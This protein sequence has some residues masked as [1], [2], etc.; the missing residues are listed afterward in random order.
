MAGG[1]NARCP[2]CNV[3]MPRKGSNRSLIAEQAIEDFKVGKAAEEADEQARVEAAGALEAATARAHVAQA[4]ADAA[5]A[6]L[7]SILER[8]PSPPNVVTD[9]IMDVDGGQDEGEPEPETAAGGLDVEF[10]EEGVNEEE[11]AVEEEE[12]ED[13]A[14]EAEEEEEEEEEVGEPVVAGATVNDVVESEDEEDDH[15]PVN[16]IDKVDELG[17]TALYIATEK[18]DVAAV[19]ALVAAGAEVDKENT[20]TVTPL[21]AAS[22]NGHVAVV[23]ALLR[24]G[25]AVNKATDDGWTP[26]H[27]AAVQGHKTVL[28]AGAYTRPLL[29]ST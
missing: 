10:E 3:H 22:E 7:A 2:T 12:V 4:R 24:A 16:E 11:A 28:A 23:R 19:R 14:E 1:V 18:G 26:L 27:G 6:L 17:R 9:T 8:P 5:E 29:S 13:E 15:A 21:Y 25:A 20:D